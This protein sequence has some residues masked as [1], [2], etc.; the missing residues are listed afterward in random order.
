M[1]TNPYYCPICGH[2]TVD[3]IGAVCFLCREAHKRNRKPGDAPHEGHCFY[4]G[5]YFVGALT[6]DHVVPLVRGGPEA[7]WNRCDACVSCNAKKNDRLP[8]EWCPNHVEAL[9]IEKSVTNIIPRMRDGRLIDERDASYFRILGIVS[10]LGASLLD[11]I[12]ALPKA[13]SVGRRTW[14]LWQ[15][16]DALR[17]HLVDHPAVLRSRKPPEE[18]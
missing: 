12:S 10:A 6:T 4:C 9:K 5:E 7:T 13:D 16:I 15:K 17:V 14:T 2:R 3:H 8:S 18:Q 11:H 1:M